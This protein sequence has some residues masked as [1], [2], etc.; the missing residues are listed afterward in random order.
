MNDFQREAAITALKLMF[1]GR[2]FNI[3]TVDKCI[4]ISGCVPPDRKDY[5]ALNA[6]HCVDFADMSANLRQMT[7]AKTMQIFETPKFDT[8]VIGALFN[9]NKTNTK[10]LNS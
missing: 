7:L 1:E 2:Y 10:L 6:L 5:Q 4:K 3:S 8:E 9:D